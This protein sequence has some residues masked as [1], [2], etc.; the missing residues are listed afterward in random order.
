MPKNSDKGKGKDGKPKKKKKAKTVTTAVIVIDAPEEEE[1]KGGR[2]PRFET[3]DELENEFTLYISMCEEKRRMPTKAG[4]MVWLRITRETWSKYRKKKTFTD[5]I[6]TIDM[7]IEDY[8]VQKLTSPGSGPIF[9]LKN[10]FK[11][12]YKDRYDVTSK[13][14]RIGATDDLKEIPDEDLR[15]IAATGY[16]GTGQ[17]R[18][19]QKASA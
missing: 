16:A 10:A 1:N 15:N 6:K 8:W 11:E 14:K 18:T 13:G 5:T 19:G 17:T 3:V 9:Y 2:P 7:V 4:L 12:H